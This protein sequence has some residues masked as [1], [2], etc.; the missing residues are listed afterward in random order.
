MAIRTPLIS[1]SRANKDS[2]IMRILY[3][4]INLSC[5]VEWLEVTES[6]LWLWYWFVVVTRTAWATFPVFIEVTSNTVIDTTW[7]K[8]VWL[9]VDQD[10]IDNPT[11]V[12][13][14]MTNVASIQT[15]ASYPVT[16]HVKLASIASWVI[17]DDRVFPAV[18]WLKRVWLQDNR[19]IIAVNGEW[20]EVMIPLWADTQALTSGGE[21]ALP[22][23]ESP[24]VDIAWLDE[25]DDTEELDVIVLHRP[26]E[27][28]RKK[29]WKK[30]IENIV[31]WFGG[32]SETDLTISSWTTTIPTVW[33][34]A[35]WQYNNL[36]ISW[37]AIL[38]SDAKVT[39]ITC[40]GDLTMTWGTITV[41]GKWG[42]WGA[43]GI[44]SNYSPWQNWEN[45]V[46]YTGES[47]AVW[48]GI[49]SASSGNNWAGWW[50]LTQ[51]ISDIMK[52]ISSGWGWGGWGGYR[53]SWSFQTPNWWNGWWLLIIEVAGKFTFSGG[54]I[55]A[56]WLVGGNWW[57]YTSS[58]NGAWGGWGWGTII[59]FARG[60]GEIA[61]T[62]SAKWGNSGWFVNSYSQW[63]GWGGWGGW[64]WYGGWWAGALL[65]WTNWSVWLALWVTANVSGWSAVTV[66]ANCYWW[67][68]WGWWYVLFLN[69]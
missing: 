69:T 38:T 36:T 4:L 3:T 24:N 21:S 37:S 48:W 25:V 42:G 67:G 51:L 7:T 6:Q 31:P 22:S 39:I 50:G 52:I 58:K 34:I 35:I 1:W 30:A 59:V 12:N 14:T 32:I 62:V 11:L 46:F 44:S 63:L 47:K 68:W 9:E 66:P 5:V 19:S 33:G 8:K 26:W 23:F 2:D 64:G 13:A 28:N 60:Y 54:T 55:E 56:D 16:P 29:K 27:W 18:K 53:S 61:W 17:T 41:S 20:D 43:W 40:K 45:G 49:W 15:W 10:M 57:S 65:T